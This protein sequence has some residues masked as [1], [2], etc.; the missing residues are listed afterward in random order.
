MVIFYHIQLSAILQQC[1]SGSY[2]YFPSVRYSGM[3]C[4]AA[5]K[6]SISNICFGGGELAA[7]Y[8]TKGRV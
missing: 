2:Q 4:R 8:S 5:G 7:G 6:L 1:S 3:L